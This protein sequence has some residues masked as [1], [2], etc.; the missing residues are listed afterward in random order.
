MSLVEEARDILLNKLKG[1]LS[2]DMAVTIR[3]F[4]NKIDEKKRKKLVKK[5]YLLP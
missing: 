3:E 1:D 4:E 5:F 2:R